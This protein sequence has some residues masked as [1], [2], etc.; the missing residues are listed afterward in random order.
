MTIIQIAYFSMLGIALLGYIGILCSIPH[1]RKKI[2]AQA[3]ACVKPLKVASSKKW[4]AIAVAGF[5]LILVVPLRNYS[6]FVNKLDRL[7]VVPKISPNAKE[8]DYET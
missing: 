4:V 2:F 7:R 1:R 8:N 3:G 5:I 6:W